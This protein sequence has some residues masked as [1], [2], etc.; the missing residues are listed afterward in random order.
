[1]LDMYTALIIISFAIIFMIIDSGGERADQAMP[2]FARD[3]IKHYLT[4]RKDLY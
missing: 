3:V 2:Q 4:A 1:M